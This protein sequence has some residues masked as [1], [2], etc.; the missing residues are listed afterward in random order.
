MPSKKLSIQNDFYDLKVIIKKIIDEKKI[1]LTLCS[2]LMIIGFIY[3]IIV[4]SSKYQS[5]LKIKQLPRLMLGDI[6]F[7]GNAS[8]FLN[9]LIDHNHY[10]IFKDELSN[11]FRKEF[12][13]NLNS[14]IILEKYVAQNNEIAKYKSYL[15]KKGISPEKY[16]I[17]NF[18]PKIE[19]GKIVP[20]EFTLNFEGF[21]NGEKFIDDYVF[22]VKK[23]SELSLSRKVEKYFNLF[24][25]ITKDKLNKKK[26]LISE[27]KLLELEQQ[28]LNLDELK[29][30]SKSFNYQIE[31]DY[32][33]FLKKTSTELLN[34]K[35]SIDYILLGL[36][37]GLFFSF[38]IIFFK[39]IIK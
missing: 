6:D 38:V 3:S 8:D 12:I 27:N 11:F 21:L 26:V 14:E 5:H 31:L 39:N 35:H 10:S 32:N 7:K 9:I 17:N 24:I 20:N 29:E 30:K 36:F 16:F 37:S 34:S 22:F 4:V 18:K 15:E 13:N 28:I 2:M 1:I 25:K 19:R 23:Q 33:P